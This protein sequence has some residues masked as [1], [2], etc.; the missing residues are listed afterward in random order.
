MILISLVGEQPIPNLLPLWQFEQIT[1]IQLAASQSTWKRAEEMAAAIASDPTLKRIQ[2]LDHLKIEAYHIQHSRLRLAQAVGNF[3]HQDEEVWL[4]LTGGTKI[5]SLAAMQS[6]Y[7][8]GITLLYTAMESDEFIF[9][10]SDGSES[11]RE[12]IQVDVSVHQYL[13]AY[14]FEVSDNHLFR[15]S[16]YAPPPS[17]KPGDELE[18]RVEQAARAS[19]FFDDVRRNVHIRK[20]TNGGMVANELDVVVTR[21]GRLAVCS[22]KATQEIDKPVLYELSS[23]MRREYAGIYCGKVLATTAEATDALRERAR[24]WGIQLVDAAQLENIAY[25]LKLTTD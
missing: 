7:G 22:C 13:Q 11:H 6:A 12:A 18:K 1:R 15:P 14:G 24:L 9:L 23:L 8:T 2:V 3:L 19:G 20:L 25:Y 4:N 21:N 5:M 16:N 10:H 17:P